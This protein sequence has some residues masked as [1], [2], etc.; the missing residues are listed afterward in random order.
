MNCKIFV[1]L[2]FFVGALAAIT[3]S[4]AQDNSNEAVV[5]SLMFFTIGAALVIGIGLL[6]LFLRKR[7]NRKATERVLNPNHPSNKKIDT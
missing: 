5:P 6:V 2:A 1:Q 4:I 7:S 3:P